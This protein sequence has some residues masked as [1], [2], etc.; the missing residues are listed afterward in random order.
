[1]VYTCTL[2]P[3]YVPK[4]E[5]VGSFDMVYCALVDPIKELAKVVIQI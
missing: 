2:Y 5:I 4:T 1:M 3:E